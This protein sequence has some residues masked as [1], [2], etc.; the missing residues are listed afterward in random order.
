MRTVSD[1][2]GLELEEARERLLRAGVQIGTISETRPPR[3]I[4]LAGPL[5]VVRARG[6]EAGPVDLVVCHERYVPPLTP[7]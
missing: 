7:R 4:G 5:R 2:I 1:F 3:P 6:D